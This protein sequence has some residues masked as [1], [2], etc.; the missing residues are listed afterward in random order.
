MVTIELQKIILHAYHGIYE[1]EAKVGSD[2]EVN[3]S[4][5][6]DEGKSNFDSI[7]ATIK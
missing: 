6:Y 3:L 7:N 1:G 2:Y 4:V 5:S